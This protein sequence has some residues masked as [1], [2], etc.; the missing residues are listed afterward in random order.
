MCGARSAE[1]YKS[2]AV[3]NI[4]NFPTFRSMGHVPVNLICC[5][6]RPR[7]A[8]KKITGFVH[9]ECDHVAVT[10]SVSFSTSNRKPTDAADRFPPTGASEGP[11]PVRLHGAVFH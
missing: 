1:L 2:R 7:N 6:P 8:D 10:S 4:V 9:E 11:L 5:F 3:S